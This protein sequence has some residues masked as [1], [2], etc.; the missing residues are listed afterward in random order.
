MRGPEATGVP[1]HSPG[2]EGEKSGLG[3]LRT[4]TACGVT[5]GQA[6]APTHVPTGQKE[7]NK[8]PAP[9]GASVYGGG[10]QW[11]TPVSV[12]PTKP[13]LVL[14]GALIRTDDHGKLCPCEKLHRLP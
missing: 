14:G 11:E 3:V 9:S 6:T 8:G 1:P 13:G 7:Q 2:P 12:T 5:G 10:T 4:S